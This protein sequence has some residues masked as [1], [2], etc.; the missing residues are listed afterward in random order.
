MICQSVSETNISV[1][2]DQKDADSAIYYIHK[3]FLDPKDAH[4]QEIL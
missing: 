1:V 4:L 2:I 3:E